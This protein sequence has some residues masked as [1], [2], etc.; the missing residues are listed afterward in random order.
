MELLQNGIASPQAIAE[1]TVKYKAIYLTC[2]GEKY[3]E[4]FQSPPVPVK[5]N[6]DYV[7]I[8]PIWIGRGRMRVSVKG[9][10][11]KVYTSSIVETLEIE[12]TSGQPLNQV[13][14]VFVAPK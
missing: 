5:Q 3:G 8:V 2:D 12:P 13:R 6:A 10:T 11:G 14:L 9:S 7:F 1:L 4:Q